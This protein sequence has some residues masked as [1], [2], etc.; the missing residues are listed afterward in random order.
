MRF[1]VPKAVKEAGRKIGTGVAAVGSVL[2]A[3]A[4]AQSTTPGAAIAGEMSGGKADMGLVIAACAVLL[5]VLLVWA[6]T[7]RSAK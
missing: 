6:Y 1:N 3:L 4:F 5:G 7:R 2:P